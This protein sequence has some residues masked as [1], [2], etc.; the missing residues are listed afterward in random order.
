L[1]DISISRNSYGRQI[2]SFETDISIKGFKA[3]VKA[4][5]IRA[6]QIEKTGAGVKILAKHNN[7]PVMLESDKILITTFHPELT[8]DPRIH[9][10]FLK[11]IG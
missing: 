1:I 5:F 6:P 11:M 2:D 10:Y 3:P 7:I 8:D 9:H 4:I